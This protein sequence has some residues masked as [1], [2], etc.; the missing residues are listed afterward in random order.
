MTKLQSWVVTGFILLLPLLAVAA[1]GNSA[2][3]D[4]SQPVKVAGTQL[5]PGVYKIVWEGVG[6]DVKVSFLSG[7]K[8]VATAPAKLAARKTNGPGAIETATASDNV[9]TLRAIEVKNVSLRFDASAPAT[10]G[11]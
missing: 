10:A 9:Q 8:Q 7:K 1:S 5:A 2:T 11:E 3:I 6:P 4:F